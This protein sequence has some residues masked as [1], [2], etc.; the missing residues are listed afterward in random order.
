MILTKRLTVVLQ[1]N[2]FLGLLVT[3]VALAD[4]EVRPTTLNCPPGP[5]PGSYSDID[6]SLSDELMYEIGVDYEFGID[7]PQNDDAAFA[8]YQCAAAAGSADA[9]NSVGDAY[10]YGIVVPRS[11]RTA[12]EFYER[13]ADLDNGDALANLAYLHFEREGLP[14]DDTKAVLYAR[15]A[16][17]LGSDYGM[18]QL[19]F[20]LTNGH[21]VEENENE[22]NEWRFRRYKAEK[23]GEVAIEIGY[24]FARGGAHLPVS[25]SD[26]MHWFN[27]A[28]LLGDDTA[29][30]EIARRLHWGYGVEQDSE[31]AVALLHDVNNERHTE[32]E[33]LDPSLSSRARLSIVDCKFDHYEDYEVICGEAVLPQD[34]DDP[35]SPTLTLPFALRLSASMPGAANP[36]V[37]PGGG[38][39]GSPVGLDSRYGG[40]LSSD[41]STVLAYGH[42]L[43]VIDQRGAGEASP[44]LSCDEAETASLASWSDH[45]KRRNVKPYIDAMDTCMDRFKAAGVRVTTFNTKASARD[46]EEVRKA[47]GFTK[48]IV[49]GTSYGARVALRMAADFPDSVASLVLDSPDSPLDDPGLFS[50]ALSPKEPLD[51]VI[52]A[53]KSSA[54]C[55]QSYPTIG[56]DVEQLLRR[57]ES[58]PIELTVTHPSS[59]T[60]VRMQ[61][62]DEDLLSVVTNIAYWHSESLPQALTALAKGSASLMEV[63]IQTSSIFD[64]D[65][66]HGLYAS[67]ACQE[68]MPLVDLHSLNETISRLKTGR[69]SASMALQSYLS[70]CPNIFEADPEQAPT[71]NLD[72]LNV[73]TLIMAGSLDP[74]T[75]A[76]SSKKLAE[77]LP[78]AW[79]QEYE[80]CGHGAL[81]CTPCA[82][83]TLWRFL[84]NPANDPRNYYCRESDRKIWWSID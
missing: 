81:S 51:R 3:S 23:T 33:G 38:G 59:L 44:S 52:S 40:L 4:G 84:E 83:E 49:M 39:P 43:I 77:R 18:E 5:L 2:C 29:R 54:S 55:S 63:Q 1:V 10:Y 17:E 50:V 41:M 69:L 36:V 24:A 35:G 64:D 6:T 9:M 62:D 65:F 13:A 16:A 82:N 14:L 58:N 21:G 8:W 67:I 70:L 37:I 71:W 31:K 22:A 73:P 57:L 61:L 47:L 60:D 26:A 42:D 34:Y 68:Q 12:I 74:V 56:K 28:A 46:F 78:I 15:R 19:V 76:R 53:C 20:A 7:L 32:A 25:Q 30:L 72:T 79:Y 66:S 27:Q 11:L 48:W 75:P 80:N 45:P